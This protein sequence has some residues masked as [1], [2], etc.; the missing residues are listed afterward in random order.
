MAPSCPPS[1]PIRI[2][3]LV[4]SEVEFIQ[5]AD[6]GSSPDGRPMLTARELSAE[7]LRRL[8]R[9]AERRIE[10]DLPSVITVPP[11]FGSVADS[12][13]RAPR[14]SGDQP[15]VPTGLGKTGS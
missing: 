4:G 12:R 6:A 13:N 15:I 3:I 8:R 2:A 1:I 10:L 11:F 14:H 5:R 9:E 7:I